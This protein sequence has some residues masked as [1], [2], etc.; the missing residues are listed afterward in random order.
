MAQMNIYVTSLFEMPHYVATL[1]PSHLVS[2]IQPE[3]QPDTPVEI[4]PANHLRVQVH[5]ISQPA[6][7]SIHPGESH[8]RQMIDFLR[9]WPARSPLLVHCYAGISRS[10]AAALIARVVKSGNA[11]DA[12]LALRRAAPHARPNSLIIDLADQILGL[13]GGLIEARQAMGDGVPAVE[14]TLVELPVTG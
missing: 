7:G 1:R 2:I 14:G 4:D 3:F 13:D 10:T 11:L 12:A 6:P 8:I 9:D 5:D